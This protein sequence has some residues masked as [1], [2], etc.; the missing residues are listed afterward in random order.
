M[1]LQLP[2]NTLN[3]EQ[4]VIE[5][6]K[7]TALVG[8]NG[9]G[10]SSILQSIFI[11]RLSKAFLTDKRVVC[12]SSGQNEKYSQ[13]FSVYLNQERHANR[14]LSLDCCYYDKSWSRLLIFLSTITSKNGLVRNFLVRNNYIVTSPN[15]NCDETSTLKFSV[16]VSQA[17][18]NRVQKALK[19]EEEGETETLRATGYHRTL[20]SFLTLIIDSNYD[21]NEPLDSTIV[22]LN[23]NN[24]NN[25]SYLET[26]GDYFDPIVSFYTQAADNDY[27]IVK[28]SM[29]LTFCN[30]LELSDLSD[31]EYQIL[32]LY[33][34][35]DLFDHPETVF[36]L[37][38]IDSHLH[39][40]NIENL[41]RQLHLIKGQAITST[42]LIDSI[43][44]PEN[45]IN[46]L[47]VVDKGKI[48]ELD[49]MKE[50]IKRLSILSRI[51]NA[52]LDVCSK[53]ENIILLDDYN[54]W[55]IFLALSKRK[56]L[57]TTRLSC[58]QAV[59][60]PSGC[61]DHTQ[62][63][64][65]S[66]IDW[67]EELLDFN[68][69]KQ[70]LRI[71]IIC[72]KDEA[73]INFK[74]DGVSVISKQLEKRINLIRKKYNNHTSIYL[75]CWKRREIK[76]YLLSFTALQICNKLEHVN[77]DDLP[78]N[79]YL[80]KNDPCDN[81]SIRGL[82][83]KEYISELID[84]DYIGLDENKL[85]DYIV[86]IPLNEISIDIENMYNFLVHKL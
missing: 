59:K 11:N 75:L 12:F 5:F 7:I 64:A 67:I 36:L 76:N 52:Q 45:S 4:Q 41:W 17:Y 44:A 66:K 47:K 83:V 70:P 81:D 1:Q 62:E 30:N 79:S 18:V 57:D 3:N 39:Y 14:G 33:S 16:R 8:G 32:F 55:K 34:L 15:S 22:H 73:V 13:Y 37:D 56:G 28:P 42:H 53:L 50:L 69:L 77:N 71:F 49:K 31:G 29:T 78:R 24:F 54:D 27:F 19:D 82:R 38:E 86:K 2:S 68:K 21:F 9:S 48:L 23:N 25:P 46:T 26:E 58:V 84:S 51:N 63:F 61:K 65:T 40:K 80:K 74:P 72:D 60:H 35:I 10:K 85:N 20:E 43:T 6:E